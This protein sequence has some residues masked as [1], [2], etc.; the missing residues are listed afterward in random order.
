MGTNETLKKIQTELAENLKDCAGKFTPESKVENFK[1][2][3][4][5]YLSS[6]DMVK[7]IEV[8]ATTNKDLIDI[9]LIPLDP[10]GEEF[11]KQIQTDSND[12][13]P[14]IDSLL[15]E[16]LDDLIEHDNGGCNRY[17]THEIADKVFKLRDLWNAFKEE[18]Q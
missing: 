9:E 5:S 2:Q 18:K 11:V 8:K 7:H 1:K 16:I 15:E 12:L 3:V 6:I 10:I 17:T 4:I 14:E 13:K